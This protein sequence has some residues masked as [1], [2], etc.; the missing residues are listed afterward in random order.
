[1]YFFTFPENEDRADGG[2]ESQPG[3]QGDYTLL[4]NIFANKK[5]M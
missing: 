4:Y 1:M 3:I 2:P 5:N